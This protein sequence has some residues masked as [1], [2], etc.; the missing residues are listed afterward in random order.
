MER[1][2]GEEIPNLKTENDSERPVHI[3]NVF[4]RRNHI[5]I[6]RSHA[7]YDPD[8]PCRPD[9]NMQFVAN[10]KR[11]RNRYNGTYRLNIM[12]DADT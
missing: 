3:E 1:R 10:N 8:K 5:S 4:S 11:E 9:D 12:H 6:I 7:L 2:K